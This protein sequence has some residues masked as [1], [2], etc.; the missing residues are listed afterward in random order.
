M[1]GCVHRAILSF[2]YDDI[3]VLGVS[4]YKTA[5]NGAIF[6]VNFFSRRNHR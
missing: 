5:R 2:I 1:I 4:G 3:G 6:G